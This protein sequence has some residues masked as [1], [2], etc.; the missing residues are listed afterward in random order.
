M[1]L[2]SIFCHDSKNLHFFQKAIV[3]ICLALWAMNT[4]SQ[5]ESQSD[6]KPMK[7][8]SIAAYESLLTNGNST[9]EL[10]TD[11]RKVTYKN[12][13]ALP[14][15]ASGTVVL[16]VCVNRE[17]IP[18]YTEYLKQST[19]TNRDVIKKCLTA[20]KGYR[21]EPSISA[22]KEQCGKMIINFDINTPRK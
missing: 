1:K 16:K 9:L 13:K 6:G 19:I 17:G 12:F 5:N 18:I 3:T 21:Y 8:D 7:M 15:T 10:L 20:A 4:Y 22:P 14:M 2:S 11:Y